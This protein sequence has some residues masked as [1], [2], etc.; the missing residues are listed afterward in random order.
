LQLASAAGIGID[1]VSWIGRHIGIRLTPTLGA[2]RLEANAAFQVREISGSGWRVGLSLRG[3][4]GE[5]EAGKCT[6]DEQ[7]SSK[8]RALHV[9]LTFLQTGILAPGLLLRLVTWILKQKQNGQC[10]PR[11]CFQANFA[12]WKSFLLA[13]TAWRCFYHG[14]AVTVSDPDLSKKM[15]PAVRFG[16]TGMGSLA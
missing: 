10:P 2:G 7:S 4:C 5:H 12:R 6:G 3:S 9:H 11:R 16:G 1:A 8:G 14:L 13:V 15:P